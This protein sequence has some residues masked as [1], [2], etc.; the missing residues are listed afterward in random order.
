MFGHGGAG[1]SLGFADPKAD[2]SFG[3][4]MNKMQVVADDD[5]RTVGL[6]QAMHDSLKG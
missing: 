6:A 2:I 3:Y 1:G 4:V 5:P